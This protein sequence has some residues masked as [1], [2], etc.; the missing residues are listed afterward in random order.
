MALKTVRDLYLDK[1]FENNSLRHDI[2]RRQ[3]HN[4]ITDLLMYKIKPFNSINYNKLKSQNKI[5][6]NVKFVNKCVDM[7]NLPRIFRSLKCYASQ[8]NISKPSVVFSNTIKISSKYFN[9]NDSVNNFV[10]INDYSCKCSE[11][12]D[13]INADC[14]NVVTGD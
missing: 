6:C 9:Y 11:H 14:E 12:S 3:L 7:I 2:S 4:I 5:S 8:F 1:V 10:C 13:F